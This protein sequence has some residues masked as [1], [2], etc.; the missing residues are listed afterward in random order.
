MVGRQRSTRAIGI[1]VV[2]L[3]ALATSAQAQRQGD[4]FLFRTVRGSLAVRGGFAL[5]S[6]RSDLFSFTTSQLTIDR[7]DFSG[8]SFGTD[9]SFRVT[10]RFDLT[11]GMDYTGHTV[12]S[13][14]RDWV[15][16]NDLPIRQVTSFRR[17]PVAAS[18]KMYLTPHGRSIGQF[19]WIPARYA[20]YAGIGGGAMWYRFRQK[21]DF[22]DFETLAVFPDKFESSGWVPM[23]HALLGVE[24]SLT[25]RFALLA[26]GR[27]TYAK[28]HLS[29]DFAGFQPLDLSGASA[30]MG[31]AVRY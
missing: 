22:V 5:A 11:L 29:D 13:E 6:A 1:A 3:S 23:A 14:F 4:G 19:A 10:P 8:G 12:S 7:R 31:V 30:T 26:E 28:A 24:L 17:V 9:L 2:T 16:Q 27:Y 18:L 15:D 21:G 25:P 20:V